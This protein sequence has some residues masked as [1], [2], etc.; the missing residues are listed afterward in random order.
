M[1]PLNISFSRNFCQE[2]KKKKCSLNRVPESVWRNT[3]L[4]RKLVLLENKNVI[5]KAL[6][7]QTLPFLFN[8]IST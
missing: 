3:S 6:A 2:Q 5:H 8:S 7:K 1:S 4:L